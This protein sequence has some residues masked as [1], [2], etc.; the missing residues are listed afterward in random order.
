MST[1]TPAGSRTTGR[2]S[3]WPTPR[4]A[5]ASRCSSSTCGRSRRRRPWSRYR[6]KCDEDFF[7]HVLVRRAGPAVDGVAGR[8]TECGT[9]GVGAVHRHV[10]GIPER[11]D[12]SKEGPHHDAW[13]L[14]A[15]HGARGGPLQ[16]D[17]L[18][19]VTLFAHRD[20]A[21]IGGALDD[22]HRR[23]D[24]AV[25]GGGAALH[26]HHRAGRLGTNRDLLL[27]IV[28]DGGAT[29]SDGESEKG[30]GSHRPS[31]YSARFSP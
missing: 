29:G 3:M 9:D 31:I 13:N 14:V 2:R 8:F 19:P 25:D 4:S 23:R 17:R 24:A 26:A 1:S 12:D 5:S 10:A 30:D 27:L 15:L 6:I 22:D 28:G 21:R 16:L 11:G 7:R 20:G 18:L